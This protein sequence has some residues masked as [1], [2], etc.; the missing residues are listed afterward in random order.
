MTSHK[1]QMPQD[2]TK[3]MAA[4][5]ILSQFDITA[6]ALPADNAPSKGTSGHFRSM[7]KRRML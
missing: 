7:L 6:P 4:H 2:V 5:D 3:D 1:K